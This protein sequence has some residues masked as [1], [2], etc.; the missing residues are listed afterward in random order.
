[1]AGGETRIGFTFGTGLVA[2]FFREYERTGARGT[3]AALPLV[4][5][6]FTESFRTGSYADKILSPLPCRLTV[7]SRQLTPSAFSLVIASVLP[8]VGLHMRVTYRGGEDARR[9]H[10]VASPLL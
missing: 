10:L 2:K 1:D 6:V 8:D 4:L 5:R 7:E 3:W 9:P